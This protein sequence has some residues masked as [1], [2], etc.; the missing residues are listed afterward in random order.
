ISD[1]NQRPILLNNDVDGE[2]SIHGPRL[3][4]EAQCNTLNHV[5]NVIADGSDHGQ[6]FPIVPPFVNLEPL[7]LLSKKAQLYVD[8][9]KSLQRGHFT[10]TVR[11][12]RETPNHLS[13]TSKEEVSFSRGPVAKN[14]TWL[15]RHRIWGSYETKEAVLETPSE[16]KELVKNWVVPFNVTSEQD[17]LDIRDILDIRVVALSGRFSQYRTVT[18]EKLPDIYFCNRNPILLLSDM[19]LTLV[20]HICNQNQPEICLQKLKQNN[21]FDDREGVG[22]GQECAKGM[23]KELGKTFEEERDLINSDIWFTSLWQE[24]I[25]SDKCQLEKHDAVATHRHLVAVHLATV[26][27]VCILL[28]CCQFENASDSEH[29]EAQHT[30]STVHEVALVEAPGERTGGSN[31][32]AEAAAPARGSGAEGSSRGLGLRLHCTETEWGKTELGGKI[33]KLEAGKNKQVSSTT[34]GATYLAGNAGGKHLGLYKA[35]SGT[36]EAIKYMT[37]PEC[38]LED[39]PVDKREAGKT[40]IP[41]VILGSR[42]TSSG[43]VVNAV[44]IQRNVMVIPKS[45]TSS[46]IREN[47]QVATLR[48]AQDKSPKTEPASLGNSL[49]DYFQNRLLLTKAQIPARLA[50]WALTQPTE[51]AQYRRVPGASASEADYQQTRSP[52]LTSYSVTASSKTAGKRV[53]QTVLQGQRYTVMCLRKVGKQN[54]SSRREQMMESEIQK[55]WKLI[56][57]VLEMRLQNQPLHPVQ[58]YAQLLCSPPSEGSSHIPTLPHGYGPPQGTQGN[59]DQQAQGQLVPGLLTTHPKYE[60]ICHQ[61]DQ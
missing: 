60:S 54:P 46:Q 38:W 24:S 5:L 12:F 1:F 19:Q 34:L 45:V 13:A 27:L 8:V 15:L 31:A 26:L 53:V 43:V 6:F 22:E 17:S 29:A 18:P 44:K 9:L 56:K 61:Q 51:D 4:A 14:P 2:V 40:S 7:L 41:L 58:I 32:V 11:P 3:V 20:S 52:A 50:L 37:A 49:L 42:K 28:L 36:Q 25:A 35:S 48:D 30:A 55:S 10:M 59:K 16:R 21:L 23:T 39:E 57:D 33:Q 47:I